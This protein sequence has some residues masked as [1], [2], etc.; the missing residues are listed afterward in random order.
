MPIKKFTSFEEASAD[1]WVFNPDKEYYIKLKEHFA[2][3]SKLSEKKANRGI[4]K[5][6]NH[7]EYLEVKMKFHD[8]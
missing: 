7:D 3:W 1:L 8:Q 4:K 6:K 5:F 2:F